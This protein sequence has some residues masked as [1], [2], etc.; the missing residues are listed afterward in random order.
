MWF[1][2]E[3][4]GNFLYITYIPVYYTHCLRICHT[5]VV[6]VVVAVVAVVVVAVVVFVFDFAGF[7]TQEI[8]NAFPDIRS[9]GLSMFSYFLLI[10]SYHGQ[11]GD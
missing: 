3:I 1:S 4:A 7:M 6:V 5:V 9:R 11:Y 10:S 8:N 2:P